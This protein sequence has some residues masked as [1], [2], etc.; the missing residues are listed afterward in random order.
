MRRRKRKRKKRTGTKIKNRST[1]NKNIADRR[2]L[3][4]RL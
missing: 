3:K 1:W 4:K 2:E